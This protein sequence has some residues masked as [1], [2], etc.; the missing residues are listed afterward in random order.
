MLILRQQARGEELARS[1]YPETT[2]VRPAP[3]FG[4]EDNLLHKLAR[5]A[6]LFTA[7]HMQERFWPVHVRQQL[8]LRIGLIL[9]MFF[10]QAID[11]GQ[12]LE[13][14]LFEDWTAAQTFELYGPTNYSTAEISELVDREII[15]HRRHIN[16]PPRILKPATYWLNR[17]IFW[18]TMSAQE[19]EK[20]FVDQE[21]DS[22]AKTFKDL[23]IEPAELANLTF[24]YLVIDLSVALS[25][26]RY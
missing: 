20:E 15:K 4:F 23:N 19:V 25:F 11:V 3:M 8:V 16:V 10:L 21:I 26:D 1:I 22:T 14:M 9:T 18:P 12:A 5:A 6:N 13:H 7:N 2:I 17:L 24:S